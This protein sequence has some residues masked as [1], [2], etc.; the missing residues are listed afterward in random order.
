M[1]SVLLIDDEEKLRKLMARIIELEKIDVIQAENAMNGLK[2]MEKQEFDV[3]ICDV[4]L[5]DANGVELIPRIKKMQPFAEIILLTA[6]GNIPDSVQAIK[7]GAFDYITKGDDNNRIIPLVYRALEKVQLS[8]K[9]SSLEQK[10]EQKYSFNHIIGKS[11]G[12]LAAIELGKKVAQTDATVLLTGET[13]TGKE[14]FAQSIHYESNRK[15]K[16]LVAI[17]CSAFSKDL[18]ES[19]LFGYKAGAFTGALKDKRGLLEEAHEGTLF[20]DEIGEMPTELQAKILRVIETKEYMKIGDTKPQ[21]VDVR[22]IA[23]TNR[24]LEKEINTGNFRQDLFYRLSIFKIHLPPLRERKSD[25]KLFVNDFVNFFSTKFNKKITAVS[26]EYMEKLEHNI[27][28]GNIRELRNVIE[29][30]VILSD[31]DIINIETLPTEIQYPDVEFLETNMAL[32]EVEKMY[33][34]KVLDYTKGNKTE[35][36]RILKIGIATLYRKIEE[37]QIA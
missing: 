7:N 20:L 14:V 16:S 25:I 17:N 18:L 9:I 5:P 12:I 28:K 37:Y 31:G 33:I 11:P 24:T 35:A 6:Y 36:A 19:E 4:R 1:K 13:G 10:I 30:S 22:I 26:S 21:K 27:W 8:R 23:A 34:K 29:R 2:W 15:N 32:A 3:I